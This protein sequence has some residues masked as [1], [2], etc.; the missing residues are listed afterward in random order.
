VALARAHA[1]K[2]VVALLAMTTAL[3]T[4]AVVAHAGAPSGPPV[5]R[6]AIHNSHFDKSVVRVHRGETVTFVVTN[7]DPIAHELIIGPA[8]VQLRHELGTEPLHGAR[9]GEVSV[10]AGATAITTYRAS[11][12]EPV[13]FACHLPGHYAYGMHGVVR[14]TN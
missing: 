2:L 6:L 3:V 10:A 1:V 13:E 8:D 9:P 12:V 14:V 5:V 4:G 11:N 7:R